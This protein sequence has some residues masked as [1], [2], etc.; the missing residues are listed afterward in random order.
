M[1]TLQ[2]DAAKEIITDRSYDA[3]LPDIW[4]RTNRRV[5]LLK[6]SR[7]LMAAEVLTIKEIHDICRQSHDLVHL[8]GV[9][10]I[11]YDGAK[12]GELRFFWGGLWGEDT[13]INQVPHLKD[14]IAAVCENSSYRAGKAKRPM[15]L[16]QN[17]F[18]PLHGSPSRR[19]GPIPWRTK[20]W[21]AARKPA[22]L[23]PRIEFYPFLT[24]TPQ[25]EHALL[26][27]V[28]KIVPKGLNADTRADVCQDLLV[29]IIS[30]DLTLAE[31]H[32]A[33]PVYIRRFFKRNSAWKHLSIDAPI[34]GNGTC[35]LADVLAA[36]TNSDD[37]Y[38]ATITS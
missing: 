15:G 29:D 20:E 4:R 12:A 22:P 2:L 27:A 16:L 26:L 14:Y 11:K 17:L 36:E 24:E 28:D 31:L 32:A 6:L 10:K 7:L 18:F 37:T 33:V 25:A 23:L 5:H 34:F 3:A 13:V 9:H 19:H 1:R 30:G 8:S 38:D 35:T 21:H